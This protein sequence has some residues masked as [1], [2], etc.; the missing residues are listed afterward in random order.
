V[1]NFFCGIRS[2]EIRATSVI[3]KNNCPK[4]QS[5]HPDLKQETLRMR[6]REIEGAVFRNFCGDF[7]GK[8][9][10]VEVLSRELFFKTFP[11]KIPISPHI[12][13]GEHIVGIS[14]PDF[15][16]GKMHENWLLFQKE[17]FC[18]R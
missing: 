1:H 11:R 5:G 17:T 12:L 9:I 4:D 18:T 10:S 2:T 14:P 13:E 3:L 7:R 6:Q 8:L 16:R 15:F